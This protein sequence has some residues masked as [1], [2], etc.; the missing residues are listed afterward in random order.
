MPALDRN[1]KVTCGNCGTSVTKKN[2]SRH[3]SRCNVGTL[4]CPK[5]PNFFTK[6]RDDLNYHIAKK[7]ATPPLKSTH[8][9]KICFKE[10]SGFYALQQHK[11]NE[12]GLQ[13][14]SAELDVSNLLEDDD[15]DLKEELQACQHF[16]V[17][18]ELEKGR[19]RVFNFALSIF[20]N[21]L[22]NKVLDLVFNGLKCAVKVNFAFGFV[23]K[24]VEDGSCRY[25]YAHEI[26]TLMERSKLV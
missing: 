17:D 9:C 7:H 22:I 14:K 15:A 25:F 24:N 19:H 26:N 20:D 13:M 1:V 11:T 21:S 4:C 5:C 12:H 6:S 3:K 16:L 23:L 18:S 8:K 10:F 2:L